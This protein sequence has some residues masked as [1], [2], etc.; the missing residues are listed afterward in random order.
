MNTDLLSHV[1]WL[2]AIVA[3]IAYFIIGGLWYSKVLF[4][5]KWATLLKIDMM[6]P[7]I[8]KESRQLCSIHFY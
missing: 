6:M 1:H 7:I 4:G 2:A 5:P 8:K 3:G